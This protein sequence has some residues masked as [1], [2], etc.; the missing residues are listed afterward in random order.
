MTIRRIVTRSTPAK[1]PRPQRTEAPQPLARLHFPYS[2][3]VEVA[4]PFQLDPRREPTRRD[5]AITPTDVARSSLWGPTPKL[6]A[7]ALETLVGNA[8]ALAHA[9]RVLAAVITAGD[10]DATRSRAAVREA[11]AR[12]ID[13]AL[14]IELV[15]EVLR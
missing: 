12:A 11:H 6:D 4:A 10:R 7:I 15:R 1:L 9:V 14:G 2:G 13:T 3:I 8:L 5:T